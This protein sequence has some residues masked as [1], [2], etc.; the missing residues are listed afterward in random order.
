MSVLRRSFIIA[1]RHLFYTLS[2]SVIIAMLVIAGIVWLSATVTERKDDIASWASEQLGYEVSIGSAGLYWLDLFPKLQLDQVTVLQDNGQTAMLSAETLHL[3]LDLLATLDK[4]SPALSAVAVNGLETE[5]RRSADNRFTLAGQRSSGFMF[6]LEDALE[7]LDRVTLETAIITYRDGPYP[8]LNGQYDIHQ[9]TLSRDSEHWHSQLTASP[10]TD[11]AERLAFDMRL[12]LAEA[13]QLVGAEGSLDI[14]D[15]QVAGLQ[16]MALLD[17]PFETD[18]GQLD[19]DTQL[20]WQPDRSQ[21]EADIAISDLSLRSPSTA[22][23]LPLTALQGR[24]QW[25]HEGPD[26]QLEGRQLQIQSEDGDWPQTAFTA[27]SVTAGQWFVSGNYLQLSDLHSFAV[28][29]PD[30]PQWLVEL[31]TAGK[32]RDYRLAYDQTHGLQSLTAAVDQLTSEP[33]EKI[34]GV[35]DLSFDI[36]WQPDVA[37]IRLHAQDWQLFA[38]Q[39]L[40]ESLWF[41]STSGDLQFRKKSD[42]WRASASDVRVLNDDLGLFLD[43]A[44]QAVGE[45]KRADISLQLDD[46]TV[47]RWLNYLP[48]QV[49]DPAFLQWSRQAFQE[50]V[51]ESM[52][53]E[54][55]GNLADFPFE[56]AQAG[57]FSADMQLR[58]ATLKYAPD[59]PALTA[60]DAQLMATGNQLQIETNH[61]Q[62]AGFDFTDVNAVIEQ[63]FDGQPQLSVDGALAGTSAAALAFL[64]ES[65]LRSRYGKVTDW[66]SVDGRSDIDLQLAVPLLAPE[67]TQVSGSVGFTDSQLTLAAAPAAPV[68]AVSG[69]L[70]FSNDGIV[71]ENLQGE[72][73]QRPANV[74]IEPIEGSTRITA[75]GQLPAAEAGRLWQGQT[76]GFISGETD[77]DATIDVSELSPGEF[78]FAAR[79]SSDLSG[80]ALALPSPLGKSA[81]QRR[82]L[83]FELQPGNS[84]QATM[85]ARLADVAQLV[86]QTG[87]QSRTVL[88][89]GKADAALSDAGFAARADLDELDLDAWQRW[90]QQYDAATQMTENAYLPERISA[91]VDRLTFRNQSLADFT[92]QAERTPNDWLLDMTGPQ[93]AG[94]VRLPAEPARAIDIDLARLHWQLP[95]QGPD[96]NTKTGDNT[97]AKRAVLWPAMDVHI[98]DLRVDETKLGM[99]EMVASREGLGWVLNSATLESEV[100]QATAEGRW[101]Q[102]EAGDNSRFSI[103]VN[104]DDLAGL[105]TELQY[106]PVIE[107]RDTQVDLNIEWPADPLGFS[108]QSMQGNMTLST[109]RGQLR[110]VEPGAAGRVFGLLS[111]TAIPRRLSLDFSD[112]FDEGMAFNSINGRFDFDNG[113]ARTDSLRLRSQS[114]EINIQ[115]PVDLVDQTYDQVVQV[116]PSVSSTLPLAGAVAGGPVGLGVGTAIMLADRLVG[117]VFDREIVDFISYR[118]RLTGP[119]DDP[120]MDLITSNDE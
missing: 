40:P 66:L 76:P 5:V 98:D 13:S 80:L 56:N 38:P 16:Q 110:E 14:S 21:G 120:K 93:L 73:L 26:W 62:T 30:L 34:P 65:P 81:Q 48:E 113:Q 52:T 12:T 41:E 87:Q 50:G 10:P 77:F 94:R 46:V 107:A 29:F 102:F 99:L 28:L 118:Y 45:Q 53:L 109:G 15:L 8:A 83:T 85:H 20:S 78:S 19:L 95:E 61:G 58:D 9:A 117:R 111:F 25:Q 11:V 36:D 64:Q 103:T 4:G 17:L 43:G 51:A 67:E 91:Q 96:S 82:Q 114:A 69:R 115:G 119:W 47:S 37:D 7:R 70:H 104:S 112:L 100:L 35:A 54:L 24:L 116:T 23:T 18:T 86:H 84:G 88:A 106:Q 60:V 74:T 3:E 63:V 89:L 79:L 33:V 32:V 105:L 31:Q 57:S 1:G 42:G 39:W 72:F 97:S 68:N 75:S 2:I 27:E 44:L 59:W 92:L 101:Q 108:R 49:L 55:N 90:Y 6:E 22:D 71:A